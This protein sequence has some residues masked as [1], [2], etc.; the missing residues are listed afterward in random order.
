MPRLLAPAALYKG[1]DNMQLYDPTSAL[2]EQHNRRAPP[3]ASIEGLR[4]GLLSNG[5]QNADHLLDMTAAHFNKNHGC[6]VLA[7]RYK[8]NAS[9]PAS[10]DTLNELIEHSD[11]L[12]TANGD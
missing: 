1:K 5:K 6:Q 11:I 7:M 10:T 9:A 8:K 2:I 4:V 12:L 3:L